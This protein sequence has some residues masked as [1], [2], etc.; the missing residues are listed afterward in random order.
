[1]QDIVDK[2]VPEIHNGNLDIL[3]YFERSF[4]N[5]NSNLVEYLLNKIISK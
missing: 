5:I 3:R 2:L 1:M 4:V